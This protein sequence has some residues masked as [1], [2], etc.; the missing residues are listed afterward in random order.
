MVGGDQE[1]TVAWDSFRTGHVETF[2]EFGQYFV[3]S[4][5]QASIAKNRVELRHIARDLSSGR[6]TQ[7]FERAPSLRTCPSPSA[8]MNS[9]Y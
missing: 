9:R 7:S 3:R 1:W 2:E 6:S 4:V 8:W 5:V